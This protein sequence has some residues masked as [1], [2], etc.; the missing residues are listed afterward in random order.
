M[1]DSHDRRASAYREFLE[2]VPDAVL[3]V[4]GSGEI[5][6]ANQRAGEMFGYGSGELE[7]R[8]VD[9]LVPE[10]F[11]AGIVPG[12]RMESFGLRRNG[13]EFPIEI[14]TGPANSSPGRSMWVVRDI[15]ARKREEATP[16]GRAQL[17]D[18]IVND[19][20]VCTDLDRRITVWNRGAAAIFGY[21]AEEALGMHASELYPPDEKNAP[22]VA[23]IDALKWQ[24]RLQVETRMRKKGGEAFYAR[25]SLSLLR[26]AG[27]S[28]SGV[29]GYAS[30]I[31]EAK[32]AEEALRESED[33]FRQIADNIQDVFW[34]TDV[35]QTR[36]LYV[37]PAYERI[38]GR[39]R[40]SLYD[41]PTSYLDIIHPED[42][43]RVSES[44]TS[45][46]PRQE[47]IEEYRIVRPDGSV[48]W[49]LDRGFAIR[50]SSGRVCRLA[51][52]ASDITQRKLAEIEIESRVLRQQGVTELGAYALHSTSVEA[53]LQETA[54]RLPQITDTE[55]CGVLEFQ[56][57]ERTLVLSAGVGW[58][59]GSV[60][61]ETVHV[62]PG[63]EAAYLLQS[64]G[65]VT[66]ENTRTESRF[67]IA[68][69][70]QNHG[71]VSSMCALI[72]GSKRPFGILCAASRQGRSFSPYDTNLFRAVGNIV[73]ATIERLRAEQES[74]RLN[75]DLEGRVVERTAQLAVL[76]GELASRNRDVE[77]ANQKAR[78]EIERRKQSEEFLK[79]V[80]ETTPTLIVL[81][82]AA[83]KLLLFNRAAER[84]TGYSRDEVLGRR[85]AEVF[86]SP[87]WVSDLER[88]SA[89]P[90][91][92]ELRSAHA[93][94]LKTKAG[95]ERLIEW[96]CAP[97]RIPW[98]DEPCI[99]SAG[100][101]IT[102]R[103]KAEDAVRQSQKLE[104]I[105]VL[106]GGVAHDFNNLLAGILGFTSMALDLLQQEHPARPMLEHVVQAGERA[107]DLTRQLLAYAGKGRV[108][109]ERVDLS[110]LVREIGSLIHA[111]IP[112]K[113]ELKI[114][115]KPDLPP[116][117]ADTGQ[118]QQLVMNLVI[119]AA[120]AIGEKGGTVRVATGI[121]HVSDG[122][123]PPGDHVYLEVAD[124][125]VGMDE[126]TRTRIFDPFFTTK[127]LGRGLGLAAVQG[128]VRGHRGALEVRTAPGEGSTFKVR[129]PAAG[130]CPEQAE[131]VA[132]RQEAADS[133][134]I[135][136]VDDEES[137]RN[138]VSYALPRF[139]YKV[140]L[141]GNGRQAIE[142][143]R[144]HAGEIS[145]ILLDLKMPVLGGDEALAGLRAIR[146]DI[147]IILSSGYSEEEA[148]RLFAGKGADAF[149]Q[150]PYTLNQLVEK[151]R[152]VLRDRVSASRA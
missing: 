136:I 108:V 48:R 128:I 84:V 53:L 116:I 75:D 56:P 148:S 145:L 7:G 112:Q 66:V 95:E 2:L 119:N 140:L 89:E 99:L 23:A 80:V 11:R 9:V 42:R 105:G 4:G 69:L 93:I 58:R 124:N 150:K 107:A 114:D 139:G 100:I 143:F 15:S 35:G 109:I 146:P 64:K 88:W 59:E 47:V 130:C 151:V 135:L 98:L 54:G 60:G 68:P 50:D 62:G 21:T 122:D 52:V 113:V 142:R 63:S 71:V 141:A 127:F 149:I 129:F 81:A 87:E 91:A 134:L 20:I 90:F 125:G 96:L 30:D 73:A 67:R 106:A 92:A 77:R 43:Q 45:S 10:R 115:L 86:Q 131:P 37:N 24:N 22:D 40:Q 94:R 26:D 61:H 31:T 82:D 16:F 70:L 102:E 51:G 27:G 49:I 25:L 110:R 133:G 147:G 36:I 57:D 44:F 29:I 65:P 126:A 41:Q 33:R 55:L 97:V 117:E 104:S 152:S 120:E 121:E 118:I 1:G 32:R 132:E 6:Q 13:A 17:I 38:W 138:F 123:A 78:Q 101:D 8:S 39:S 72:G 144:E 14:S 12:S 79:T 34:M 85:V 83:G 5:E 137:I 19:A 111:S 28:P 74:R 3:L 103:K 46:R 18:Q 76:N